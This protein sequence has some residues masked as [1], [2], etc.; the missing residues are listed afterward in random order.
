[1]SFEEFYE[2]INLYIN[3]KMSFNSL[4][5]KINKLLDIN[6]KN[7]R[8]ENLL[9]VLMSENAMNQLNKKVAKLLILRGCDINLEFNDHNI[10]LQYCGDL[11]NE[12][13]QHI[14][15]FKKLIS[16]KTNFSLKYCNLNVIQYIHR[17]ICDQDQI[18]WYEELIIKG[19]PKSLFIEFL[20]QRQ[21]T[22]IYHL[23]NKLEKSSEEPVNNKKPVA[24]N[25][26][27]LKKSSEETV[28][29][30]ATDQEEKSEQMLDNRKKLL[31]A[32]NPPSVDGIISY[33]I[34]SETDNLSNE[35]NSFDEVISYV[36]DHLNI[37]KYK[38]DQ[39]E[40]KLNKTNE[41]IE[42]NTT[43]LEQ[44][45]EKQLQYTELSEN[46]GDRIYQQISEETKKTVINNLTKEELIELLKS[47]FD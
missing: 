8:G 33:C 1:M 36:E 18:K 16:N 25:A 4:E 15:L 9:Y 23:F 27:D 7:L 28:T 41:E 10:L 39:L 19:C 32:Q 34:E 17:Y 5:D 38:R 31:L 44:L 2:S 37:L 13:Y 20:P 26:T 24:F 22:M 47:K 46:L 29:F 12:E 42:K 30:N 45:K 35:I 43:E 6:I 3:K 14:S 21:I 40:T 11:Y